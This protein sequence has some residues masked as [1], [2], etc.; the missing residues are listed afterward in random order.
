MMNE[1]IMT[2]KE[3]ADFLK[4]KVAYIYD[5]KARHKIPYHTMGSSIRYLKSEILEWVKTDGASISA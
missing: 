1:E 4:V 3:C 2:A 5:L